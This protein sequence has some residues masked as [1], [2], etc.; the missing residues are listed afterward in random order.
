[1]KLFQNAIPFFAEHFPN[2]DPDPFFGYTNNL[3]KLFKM[4]VQVLLWVLSSSEIFLKI[5]SKIRTKVLPHHF[6]NELTSSTN[7]LGTYYIAIVFIS[8]WLPP[9]SPAVWPRTLPP[10]APDNVPSLTTNNNLH[11]LVNNTK[12]L[13]LD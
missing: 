13:F 10:A 5:S 12:I 1:M 6:G 9:Q 3:G 2:D 11:D 8:A 7:T 4:D